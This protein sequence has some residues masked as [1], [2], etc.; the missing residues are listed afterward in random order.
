MKESP[1]VYFWGKSIY[2]IRWKIVSGGSFVFVFLKDTSFTP[3]HLQEDP[4]ILRFKLQLFSRNSKLQDIKQDQVSVSVL[5]F[6]RLVLFCSSS[7][8]DRHQWRWGGGG[9]LGAGGGRRGVGPKPAGRR[10]DTINSPVHVGTF[11]PQIF[12]L[13]DVCFPGNVLT[14]SQIIIIFFLNILQAWTVWNWCFLSFR[15]SLTKNKSSHT[16]DSS[17]TVL[18]SIIFISRATTRWGSRSSHVQ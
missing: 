11:H 2:L 14:F 9:S 12:T 18:I 15:P 3:V 6:W 4:P 5:W 7:G 8:A 17:I 16:A 10:V 13:S 1:C